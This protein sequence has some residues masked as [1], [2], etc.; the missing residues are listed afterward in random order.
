MSVHVPRL[1]PR[2]LHHLDPVTLVGFTLGLLSWLV[3]SW[4]PLPNLSWAA[5]VTAEAQGSRP[6]RQQ[7]QLAADA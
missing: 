6:R 7:Q 3:V 2:N 5:A 4:L 1:S